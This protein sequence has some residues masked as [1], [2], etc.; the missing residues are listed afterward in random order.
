VPPISR[1]SCTCCK[2]E[3]ARLPGYDHEVIPSGSGDPYEP[4]DTSRYVND[5]QTRAWFHALAK[6]ATAAGALIT[7]ANGHV[8]ACQPNY[9]PIWVLPGGTVNPDE[10]P[11]DCAAREVR[12][13][14]G[15]DV[16]L[17]RLLAVD[18]VPRMP[19]WNSPMHYFL[20]D[21]GVL[22]DE[23]AARI[24]PQEEE[25]LGAYFMPPD[26]AA[27]RIGPNQGNRLLLALDARVNGKTL[28]LEGGRLPIH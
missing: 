9:R 3:R 4:V 17:G 13:E 25:L 19:L 8:L 11:R 15:I 2:S 22:D 16:V 26:E 7:K 14:L 23:T 18:W 12:E 27:A 20:F 28:Y 24:R 5:D 10:T 6:V 21:G 1:R